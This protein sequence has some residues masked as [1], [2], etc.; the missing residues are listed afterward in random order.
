MRAHERFLIEIQ[1][2]EKPRTVFERYA[3]AANDDS[4]SE[5]KAEDLPELTRQAG[6]EKPYKDAL[7]AA[8]GEGPLNDVVKT[9]HGWHAIVVS[10]VLPE[11]TRTLADVEA[12]SRERLSQRSRLAKLVEI[13]EGL[14][15]KG[16]VEYEDAAVRRL[17][18]APNLPER[19]SSA[20]ATR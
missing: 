16:L 3:E 13:V 18:S 19:S 11:E 1:R 12:E 17:L 20:A 6:I 7:F 14:E 8:K 15:A 4:G 2:A 10:E 5:I 9:S